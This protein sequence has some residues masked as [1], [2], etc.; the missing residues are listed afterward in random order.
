METLTAKRP[1]CIA[2]SVVGPAGLVVRIDPESLRSEC[3]A[4]GWS[5]ARL[6]LRA[7]LSRPT[8]IKAVRGLPVRPVT[9]WR[10]QRAL[11]ADPTA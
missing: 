7:G 11:D 3:L 2:E 8:T 10:I 5:I 6:G 4:R 1:L 9:L